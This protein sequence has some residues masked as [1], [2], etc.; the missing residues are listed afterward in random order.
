MKTKPKV[1]RL[2][3]P[4]QRA[5]ILDPKWTYVPAAFTNILE[6]FRSMGWTPPSEAKR[7]KHS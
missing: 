5:N 3:K 1:W 4:T 6:R 7:E 2:A